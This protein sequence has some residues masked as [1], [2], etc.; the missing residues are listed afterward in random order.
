MQLKT[1]WLVAAALPFIFSVSLARARDDRRADTHYDELPNFHRVGERLYRGGQPKPGGFARLRLLGVKT[2]VNLRDDD[3]HARAEGEEARAAGLSYY[4][5]PLG[6]LGRPSDAEVERV[7]QLIDAPENRPV[8]VHCHRGAD[9]TGVVVAIYRM[10]HDGWTA[11]RAQEEAN[12]FGMRRWQLGK[13][14]YINDFYRDHLGGAT[15]PQ[16]SGASH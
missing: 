5:V 6:R 1:R 11:E 14:D 9:R 2:V 3:E 8:F 13:K 4:N 7:L 15:P 10:T 12:R 16:Q